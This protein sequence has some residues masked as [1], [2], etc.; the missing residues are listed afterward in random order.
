MAIAA[1]FDRTDDF[2]RGLVRVE[3]KGTYGYIDS[4]GTRYWND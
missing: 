3:V 2:C 4:E 1:M